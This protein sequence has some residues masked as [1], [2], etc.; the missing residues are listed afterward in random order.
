MANVCRCWPIQ[1]G[2]RKRGRWMRTG[3][4]GVGGGCPE[5][6]RSGASDDWHHGSLRAAA[7]SVGG[8]WRWRKQPA[9]LIWRKL[10][11]FK[12]SS[13]TLHASQGW[14]TQTQKETVTSCS[15]RTLYGLNTVIRVD[16]YISQHNI[17][18]IKINIIKCDIEEHVFIPHAA[19][20]MSVGTSPVVQLF[21]T[22][23]KWPNAFI[24]NP[25]RSS[26]KIWIM[27]IMFGD[28][29]LIFYTCHQAIWVW[30]YSIESRM[31]EKM[32]INIYK[33]IW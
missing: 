24:L 1:E 13:D 4:V 30:I 31:A 32:A 15:S 27:M 21:L 8:F 33:T 19:V 2:K 23:I 7:R 5:G 11:S 18:I 16:T 14:Y 6:R 9:G 12:I 26:Q 3:S 20:W 25:M 17:L 29:V 10:E 28:I 22:L